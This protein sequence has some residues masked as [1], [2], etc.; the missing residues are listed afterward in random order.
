[1][2][3]IIIYNC[4]GCFQGMTVDPNEPGNELHMD[5]AL[6]RVV[7]VRETRWREGRECCVSDIVSDGS[8][9]QWQ[10]C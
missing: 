6:A 2:Y 4:W 10:L 1:M 7:T 5:T 8:S 3:I 9:S